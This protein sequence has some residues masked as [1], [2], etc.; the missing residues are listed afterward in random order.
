MAKKMEPWLRALAQRTARP[1]TF[2]ELA[3]ERPDGRQA[4][5]LCDELSVRF[6]HQLERLQLVSTSKSRA[7]DVLLTLHR[8][9]LRRLH[10]FQPL[11]N[12]MVLADQEQDNSKMNGDGSTPPSPSPGVTTF[13]VDLPA[14]LNA[15]L[16]DLQERHA[17]A[18]ETVIEALR[19]EAMSAELSRPFLTMRI[20]TQLLLRQ[21]LDIWARRTEATKT[22]RVTKRGLH[23]VG[24][25]SGS[26]STSDTGGEG[27][28]GGGD[29]EAGDE[30]LRTTGV[31][32]GTRLLDLSKEVVD[33]AR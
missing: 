1:L 29:A 8:D 19:S 10:E 31:V 24:D 2:R 22:K 26:A 6:S 21:H 18:N 28:V 20:A 27:G 3:A 25:S 9:T 13:R 33:E 5:L 7:L 4:S 15:G 11:V 14:V 23:A 16:K 12:K 30:G 32:P 17:A